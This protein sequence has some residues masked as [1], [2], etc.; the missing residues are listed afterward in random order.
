MNYKSIEQF[1]QELVE[2]GVFELIGDGISIQDTNFKI[3]Y[4]NSKHKSYVG[5]HAGE[6]CY[7]AYEKRDNACEGCPMAMSFEDG[8]PHTEERK[9]PVKGVI[10]YFGITASPIR[11]K[12]GTIIAG[13]EVVRDITERKTTEEAL[14]ENE[15]KYRL[16]F[17]ADQDA[18]I[19]VDA[20]TL[21]I[22]D[23][24]DSA[25]SLYGYSREEILKLTGPDLSAEQEKSAAAIDEIAEV[26]DQY[27]HYH[28]RDHKKKNG[29]VFPV[30]ISSGTFNLKK[31][32]IVSAMI[33]DIT[34]RKRME[35][36]LRAAAIT[37]DLTGL[38]NRRGFF[39][40][41][42]QQC[43]LATR[44]KRTMALVYIDMDGLKKIN[45]ELGHEEGDQA[46]EDTA[47]V[48]KT[49]FRESDIIA[50]IGGDEFAVLVTE[51]S[52]P[53]AVDIIIDHLQDN[54]NNHNEQA[55][56]N[57]EL[58]VTTGISLYDPHLQCSIGILLNQA[59]KSMYKNKTHKKKY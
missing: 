56:R 36:K 31:R 19:M 46:I 58:S 7:K 24:N 38:L 29:T 11:D 44:K 18:I 32:K 2:T 41:A 30:E 5:D 42:D 1:I 4:Q 45:D 26:S 33:R 14:R 54:I 37:D 55:N 20:E 35:H 27:I 12:T 9:A 57:Y 39:T 34:E 22:I 48:F 21:R 16:L 47:K 15:E 25:L 17:S 28:T 40:L 43:K 10:S 3:L 53:S 50:R 8:L 23:A 59:D 6:Y 51:L 52:D 49:T 13:I